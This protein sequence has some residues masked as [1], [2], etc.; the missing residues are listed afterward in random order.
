MNSKHSL[1]LWGTCVHIPFLFKTKQKVVTSFRLLN[2]QSTNW[3]RFDKK[4]KKSNKLKKIVRRKLIIH[5]QC[6]TCWFFF[7]NIPH[8]S[9]LT[10]FFHFLGFQK[11]R[12]YSEPNIRS[13]SY[14]RKWH[15]WTTQQLRNREHRLVVSCM[16]CQSKKHFYKKISKYKNI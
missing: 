9:F 16:F 15:K 11:Q 3:S 12:R 10:L 1:F 4:H 13:A 6:T 7:C 2:W 5:P 14:L 8:H